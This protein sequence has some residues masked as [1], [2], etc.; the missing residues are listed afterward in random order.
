MSEDVFGCDKWGGRYHWDL[1]GRG[2]DAIKYPPGHKTVP[3]TQNYQV[4]NANSAE[5]E[6]PRAK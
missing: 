6:K 2:Q 1:V 3:R 4:P 5:V